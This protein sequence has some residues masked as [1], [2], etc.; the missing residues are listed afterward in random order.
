MSSQGAPTADSATDGDI[1]FAVRDLIAGLTAKPWGQVAPS[2]YETGRLVTLAPWLEG[3]TERITF[4]LRSQRADGGWGPPQ[5][6]ALVPTLSATEALLATLRT[7][8]PGA[9]RDHGEAQLV[10]AAARGLQALTRWLRADLVVPDTPAADI[11]VPSLVTAIN[12]HLERLEDPPNPCLGSWH[13]VRL[14]LPAGM[15]NSRL[16][17]VRHA[18]AAGAALP[19][20]LLHFLEVLGPAARRA[21]GIHPMPPGTVGASPAATAAWIGDPDTLAPAHPARAHLTAVAGRGTVPCPLPITVFEQA[22]VVSGLARAGM[23]FAVPPEIVASLGAA[24]GP[25]GTPTGPGLPADADTTA[26]ALYALGKLGHPVEPA[27]LWTYETAD[28]FCTW[29]GED[30]FSVT[31]NAHVLDAFGQYLHS[32][33]PAPRYATATARL[34]AVL[35]EHQQP[36]GQWHDRWHASPYYAT[37]CC[38]RALNDFGRGSTAESV[39][40]AVDWVLSTQR[41]DGSWGRWDSTAEETAYALQVL[42]ST[43]PQAAGVGTVVRRGY[44]YLRHAAGRGADPP[45]WYGKELYHPRAIVRAAVLAAL[46]LA[47]Q[48]PGLTTVEASAIASKPGQAAGKTVIRDA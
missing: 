8:G 31:T 35:R 47:R 34:T 21:A 7:D 14:A 26:V 40:K 44:S 36:D 39:A 1:G 28:G 20:K 48:H 25:V 29:P 13:G 15:D 30:G 4:L 3:H 22:W 18:L 43:R 23:Q 16:A 9:Q 38:T 5:G 27:G 6:Y 45:L 24:M 10:S 41:S 17:K 11:I 19:G 33:D 42:L 32:T 46:H 37:A 12:Q 2:V